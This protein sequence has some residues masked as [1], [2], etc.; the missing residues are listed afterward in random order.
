MISRIRPPVWTVAISPDRATCQGLAFSY[1][2]RPV[3]L[4]QEPQQWR[5][6]AIGWLREEGI[7]GPTAIL[8]TGPSSTHPDY[9]HRVEFLR[10]GEGSRL[11]G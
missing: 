10:L 1:G 8:V 4:A 2:V 7:A 9:S 3:E 6:W 11:N 5:A